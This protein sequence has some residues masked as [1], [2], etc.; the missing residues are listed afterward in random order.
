MKKIISLFI[1]F[2][3]FFHPS[4]THAEEVN[5]TISPINIQV[6]TNSIFNQKASKIEFLGSDLFELTEDEISHFEKKFVATFKIAFKKDD[7]SYD[8]SKALLLSRIKLMDIFINP[9]SSIQSFL[10]IYR[11]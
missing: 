3:A 9:Y 2:L 4:I 1:V 7:Y 10:G 8:F 11:I 6:Q 5:T